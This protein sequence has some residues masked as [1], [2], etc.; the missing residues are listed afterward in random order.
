MAQGVRGTL[1]RDWALRDLGMVRLRD[2]AQSE[3]LFQLEAP[4]LRARFPALRV[5][6]ETPSNL[7]VPVSSF[8]GRTRELQRVRELL[9][10]HRLVTLVGLGGVG[11]TRIA[12]QLA[13]QVLDDHRD[14]AWL[15]EL[16][17]LHEAQSV[18]AAVAAAVGVRE[19]PEEPLEAALARYAKD[20]EVLLL[21][22]NCE[23]V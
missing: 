3:R 8:V 16:G 22:D 5:L 15:V 10:A 12:L 11:K 14:G 4:G 17:P 18:P 6:D 13:A 21:F 1:P 2:L 23:H 7:P 9:A 20:R 19:E